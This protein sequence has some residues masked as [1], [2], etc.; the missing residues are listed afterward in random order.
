M[1]DV[2]ATL[3]DFVRTHH[4]WAGPLVAALCFAESIAFLSFFVPATAILVAAGGLA[5][6]GLVPIGDMILGGVVGCL[7]GD[8]VSF[9][10]G[11][12]LGPHA[13]R[14]WPFR[15]RPEM[16][17]RGN[18]FF[19]RH[20][21]WGVFVGR[22]FGPLRAMVPLSAGAMGMRPRLFLLV[23][24]G[25]AALFVP[26]M[27]APGAV[28]AKGAD[29]LADPSGLAALPALLIFLLPFAIGAVYLVRRH[30][31]RTSGAE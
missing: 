27:L 16:L 26:A 29:G 28:V 2:I 25:S 9:W 4:A 30:I 21:W 22:F 8:V 13:D 5:G 7:L 10:L 3:S 23:S 31:G 6:A 17:A 24:L 14:V 20:G 18:A 12:R 19:A 15:S 1:P 11:R